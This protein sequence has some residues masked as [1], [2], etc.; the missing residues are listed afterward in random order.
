MD[1]KI[2]IHACIPRREQNYLEYLVHTFT[3]RILHLYPQVRLATIS[4]TI[5]FL[6]YFGI[7][8]KEV[9]IR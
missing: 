7:K 6:S 2:L 1:F 8:D 5:L 4:F 9:T 3:L